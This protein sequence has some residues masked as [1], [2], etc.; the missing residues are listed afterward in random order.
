MERI[1]VQNLRCFA[2]TGF[3]ELKPITILVGANSS[4]KSSLLRVF[5]L[6]KQSAETKTLSGLLLN[7]GDVNFGFYP[8]AVHRDADPAELKL[9]FDVTLREGFHQGG[10][11]NRFLLQ[12][13]RTSCEIGYLNR[14][15]DSRYPYVHSIQL[16]LG[17]HSAP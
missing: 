9:E 8:D 3:V 16:K 5:P 1:R 14:T 10:R 13:I 11:V 15:K 12:P 7:E 2:D 4:G 17:K 6:L